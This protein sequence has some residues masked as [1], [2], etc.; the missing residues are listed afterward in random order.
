[1]ATVRSTRQR[2]RMIRRLRMTREALGVW[3]ESLRRAGAQA[4][5]DRSRDAQQVLALVDETQRSLAKL[6]AQM[7]EGSGGDEVRLASMGTM[8]PR[9]AR[10]A[11]HAKMP[12]PRVCLGAVRACGRAVGTAFRDAQAAADAAT[13]GMLYGSLRAFEKQIWMLDPRQVR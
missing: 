2:S 5:T 11:K 4:A 8:P 12:L 13:A 6:L 1:M 7:G 3:E 9:A 10:G